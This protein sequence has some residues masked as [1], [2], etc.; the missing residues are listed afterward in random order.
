M[1]PNRSTFRLGFRHLESIFLKWETSVFEKIFQKIFTKKLRSSG[2]C[3]MN[4]Y[5]ENEGCYLHLIGV[6]GLTSAYYFQSDHPHL[7]CN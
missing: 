4:A 6:I 1:V 5:V 2:E 3:T 7:N